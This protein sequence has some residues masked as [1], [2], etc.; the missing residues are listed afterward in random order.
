MKLSDEDCEQG[1]SSQS[2]SQGELSQSVESSE[3]SQAQNSVD[4]VALMVPFSF[5]CNLKF[6]IQ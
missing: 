3:S 1:V 2:T 5:L 6:G 4:D